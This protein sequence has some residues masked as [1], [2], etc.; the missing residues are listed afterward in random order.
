MKLPNNL[1]RTGNVF[2]QA[3]QNKTDKLFPKITRQRGGSG[4]LVGQSNVRR[5]N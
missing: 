4:H 1:R 5:I 2:Q 3:V